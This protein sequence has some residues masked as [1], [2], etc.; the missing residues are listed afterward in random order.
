MAD[1][2]EAEVPDMVE[3]LPQFDDLTRT[4]WKQDIGLKRLY[5]RG[6]LILLGLQMVTSNV[7]FVLY[8]ARGMGWKVPESVMIGWLSAMV[9]ELIG[10]VAVV[11][12]YLFPRRDATPADPPGPT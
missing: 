9:V 5:A 12:R 7:I 11:T 10:V 1:P 4:D 8:A 2:T 6:L 3:R